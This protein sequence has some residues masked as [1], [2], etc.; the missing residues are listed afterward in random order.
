MLVRPLPALSVTWLVRVVRLDFPL[1]FFVLAAKLE[2][3]QSQR[4]DSELLRQVL[5]QKWQSKHQKMILLQKMKQTLLEMVLAQDDRLTM[6]IEVPRLSSR[7]STT[8]E[9]LVQDDHQ[10]T[11]G[12]AR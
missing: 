5:E 4:M 8:K 3:T 1:I 2:P 12:E 11:I 6:P 7:R 9:V 10:M